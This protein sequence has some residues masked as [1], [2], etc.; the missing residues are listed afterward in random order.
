MLT[1]T[2]RCKYWM[3]WMRS[4]SRT[5]KIRFKIEIL[6]LRALVLDAVAQRAWGKPARQKPGGRRAE[7]GT[8]PGASGGIHPGFRR[9]G[10]THAEDA[11]PDCEARSF[12]GDDSIASWRH[13]KRTIKICLATQALRS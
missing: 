7:T 2:W 13:F 9:P 11:T 1:C 10:Q 5:H 8:G 6:A 3:S 4:L 12:G